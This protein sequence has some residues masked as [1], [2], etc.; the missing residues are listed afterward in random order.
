MEVGEVKRKPTS[1]GEPPPTGV[2]TAL[3]FTLEK[4]ELALVSAG[5]ARRIL[6]PN[7]SNLAGSGRIASL[8]LR[9][10]VRDEE[11]VLL[12]LRRFCAAAGSCEV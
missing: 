9:R 2:A 11:R 12:A 7:L 4:L 10:R 1:S 8:D 6:R 5:G 3:L